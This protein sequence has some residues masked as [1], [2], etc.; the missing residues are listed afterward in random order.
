MALS[1]PPIF[2]IHPLLLTP[3]TEEFG[4]TRATFSSADLIGAPLMG[5]LFILVGRAV[6]RYGAR[7]V[8]IPGYLLFGLSTALLSQ[9]TSSVAL[10][11]VLRIVAT[12]FGALPTGVAFAKVISQ[13]FSRNRGLMLGFCLGIGGGLGMTVFPLVAAY[14]LGAFGWRETYL[15][16]G[17]VVA[18]L[19]VPIAW[20]LPHRAPG[21]TSQQAASMTG[22]SSGEAI[23]SPAFLM[24]VVATFFSCMA[25]NGTGA[26]LAALVTDRGASQTQA[27]AAL[28]IYASSMMA[29]QFA[30]GLLLDRF[31]TPRIAV[32]IFTVVAA[33]V[34]LLLLASTTPAVLLGAALM[35]AGAG[36]EYSMLPYMLTRFFGLRAF[37]LL[38]GIIYSAGAIGT[39]I[40]P[41]LMG[42]S[43]DLSGS[44]ARTLTL[45]AIFIVLLIVMVSRLPR[46]RYASDGT[47]QPPGQI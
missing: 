23:R 36:S 2:S 24:L 1:S 25:I 45:F 30:V 19:G 29:A 12:A 41:Y 40:G 47:D 4:W 35:G 11:L 32:V 16:V 38:Y 43:F 34:T 18:A 42:L 5:C 9:L 44:Y 46:Y 3:I 20:A 13:H 21:E 10:F 27:A 28:S 15:I 26:H 6:D 33:G 31:S 39:G 14:L 37:G 8:L 22:A 17:L 7:N